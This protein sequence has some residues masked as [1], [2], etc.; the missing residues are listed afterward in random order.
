MVEHCFSM[1][2]GEE[3]LVVALLDACELLL[4]ATTKDEDVVDAGLILYY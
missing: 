1:Y 2:E 3:G 4:L